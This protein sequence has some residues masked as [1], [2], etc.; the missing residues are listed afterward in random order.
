MRELLCIRGAP[1]VGKSTAARLLVRRTGGSL[2]EV[3]Q[4]RSMFVAV[5]W[6]SQREHLRALAVAAD[7]AASLLRQRFG[8]VLVVDTFSRGKLRTFLDGLA[9]AGVP[10]EAIGHVSLWASPAE[11]SRRVDARPADHFRDVAVCLAL[12]EASSRPEA[13]G[14]KVLDTTGLTPA[15]VASMI[16]AHFRPPPDTTTGGS[17]PPGSAG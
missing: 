5:D 9:A 13:D 12:N 10:G 16:M 8:P 3:D 17:P 11:L 2:L 15:D 14:E 4:L 7:L 6:V 1:G